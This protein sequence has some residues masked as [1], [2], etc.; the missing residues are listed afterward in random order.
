MKYLNYIF[1]PSAL[2]PLPSALKRVS[3]L[4]TKSCQEPTY[5]CYYLNSDESRP[6]KPIFAAVVQV[7]D[8]ISG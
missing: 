2:C 3:V 6:L 7:S 5:A 1:L 4:I 8:R